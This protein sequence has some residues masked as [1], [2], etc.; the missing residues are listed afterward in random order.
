MSSLS[1]V[2]HARGA[3]GALQL[4]SVR[5]VLERVP[6]H[7]QHQ[8]L[9]A[10]TA[11]VLD[12]CPAAHELSS[13]IQSWAPNNPILHRLAIPP[14]ATIY[15]A[16]Y[17]ANSLAGHRPIFEDMRKTLNHPNLLP[18]VTSA[19]DRSATPR[20]Y[21]YSDGDRVTAAGD[22]ESHHAE[23]V[24]AGFDATLERFGGSPHVAHMRSDPE[25]YWQAVS[26]VWRKALRRSSGHAVQSSL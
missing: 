22:V 14:I 23:A 12:S 19:D 2:T 1:G 26:A 16:F 4:S 25:R 6:G 3:G 21:I 10:P 5:K 8:T 17:V 15:A 9:S 24:T 13:A 7:G 11:L 18:S 20:V